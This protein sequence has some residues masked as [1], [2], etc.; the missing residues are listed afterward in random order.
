MSQ[1]ISPFAD[2]LSYFP[3][4]ELP[5]TIQYSDHHQF[6]KANDD[7]PD[8]LLQQFI[9]PNLDFEVDEFSEFLPC[10]QFESVKAYI[11]WFCGQPD[12][13]GIRFIWSILTNREG[14]Y[15]YRKLQVFIPKTISWLTKWPILMLLVIYTSWEGTLDDSHH[16]VNPVHTKM[17]ARIFA[18]WKP[19]KIWSQFRIINNPWKKIR[20]P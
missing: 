1:S 5:L 12:W 18:R 4:A 15:I 17:D 14:F 8:P 9:F 2:L 6:S 19:S 20:N 10:L 11:P 13:C 7:L 16:E 3:K